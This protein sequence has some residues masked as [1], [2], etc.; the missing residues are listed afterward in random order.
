M[1]FVGLKV[2]SC[3]LIV[4][5]PYIDMVCVLFVYRYVISVSSFVFFVY[6]EEVL[7]VVVMKLFH[8]HHT[9]D[10]ALPTH[11]ECNQGENAIT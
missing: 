2:Y 1:C 6:L 10:T 8:N 3:V 11:K 9:Q 5:I 4:C 7:Y